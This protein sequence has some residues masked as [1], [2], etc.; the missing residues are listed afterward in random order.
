NPVICTLVGDGGIGK[1]TLAASFPNPVFIRTEDGTKSL[2]GRSD[3][4]MFNLCTSSNDV[5]DQIEALGTQE[6]NFKTLVIDSI[7]QLQSM[8]ENEIVK[9]D[10]KAKSINTA[11]GGY[12]AGQS[13]A[14]E[15]HFKIRN[16]LDMLMQSKKMNVIAIAH[17]DSE[18]IEL[19]DSD[20]YTRYTV[21][22][23]KKSQQHWTDNVDMVAFIKL[24]KFLKGG[25]GE[26]KKAISD[27]TRI[28]TCYPVASHISKNRFGIT[29]DL[30][31]DKDSNPF[32]PFID[33]I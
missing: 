5:L 11:M 25:E 32:K 14:A 12:G 31:F 33:G 23:H 8:I 22:M 2:R 16:Y 24:Q 30:I 28:I 26:K 27:G 18:L 13:A 9:S 29:E 20:A 7:T 1:T 3:V 19:P 10:S 21:R 15:V 6:H 4:S 17:A